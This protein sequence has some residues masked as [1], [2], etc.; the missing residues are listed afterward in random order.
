[1]PSWPQRVTRTCKR[2]SA[3][4][5]LGKLAI[6]CLSFGKGETPADSEATKVLWKS[7]LKGEE[8][9]PNGIFSFR[10]TSPDSIKSGPHASG[11]NST[12]PCGPTVQPLPLADCTTT[13]V[14][15]TRQR[16]AQR[17]K[18]HRNHQ[19]QEPAQKVAENSY[20]DNHPLPGAPWSRWQPPD[21]WHD[22]QVQM[23]TGNNPFLTNGIQLH[24]LRCTPGSFTHRLQCQ[25][26]AGWLFYFY[27]DFHDDSFLRN[28]Q[29]FS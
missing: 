12:H 8:R 29:N 21:P 13:C 9:P 19:R 20:T 22:G 5:T 15:V 26:T 7:A 23:N 17:M 6:R 24:S 1:M 2:K 25:I 28:S 18:V 10:G 4:L 16:S 11:H 27:Q 3:S 14:P